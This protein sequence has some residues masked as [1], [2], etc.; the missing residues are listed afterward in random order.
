MK[1][2]IFRF[3][4]QGSCGGFT[5]IE[6][7]VVM[8]MMVVL[9]CVLLSLVSSGGKHF[10]RNE[11]I[12]RSENEARTALS[13]VTVKMRQNDFVAENGVRSVSASGNTLTINRYKGGGD[14]W[15]IRLD[16]DGNLKEYTHFAIGGTPKEDIIATGLKDF[17]VTSTN[18]RLITVE[19]EYRM[20][21]TDKSLN[22]QIYLR[23]DS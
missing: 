9:A 15:E 19:I 23:A 21:D 4:R 22:G 6:L 1:K 11:D 20:S 18:G 10:Q 7:V 8:A 13:Y 14:Y 17:K 16:S 2:S 3:R 5:M 12:Y